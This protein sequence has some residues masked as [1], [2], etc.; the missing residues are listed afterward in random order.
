[1]EK[2]II[3]VI[4]PV[5]NAEKYLDECIQSVIKQ[6]ERNIEIIIID[7]GSTDN[8]YN[9]CSK[10]QK[11]D[12]RIKIYKQK[13][14]GVS[15]ARNLGIKKSIG[16]Y[17]YFMDADDIIQTNIF[18]DFLKLK[19]NENS[20]YVFGWEKYYKNSIIEKND[21]ISLKVLNNL[22]E[23]LLLDSQ[24]SCFLFN[25][26]Y[27]RKIII[28]NNIFFDENIHY[29]E[30]MKFNYIYINYIKS[31][32]YNNKIYY[33]YRMRKNSATGNYISKKNLSVFGVFE[34]LIKDNDNNPLIYYNYCWSYII[35]Y[36]KFRKKFKNF[37]YN[38]QIIKEKKYILK[39]RYVSIN[40]KIK[41]IFYNKIYHIT[42]LK[43]KLNNKN[44]FFD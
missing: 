25:K 37:N 34:Y 31:F 21:K 6:K 10:Y 18:T 41:L 26:I 13:N 8:S 36:Y 2:P 24:I 4:I 28:D 11:K 42:F 22:K 39:S 14:A 33:Y 12:N 1:M 30:D 19:I 23:V 9:V 7:D 29:C 16:K 32:S 27:L 20:L 38:K 15:S 17:L 3:S 35:N 40:R 5:Y 43:N 44:K